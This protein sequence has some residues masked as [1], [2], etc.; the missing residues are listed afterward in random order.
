MKFCPKCGTAVDEDLP[1]PETSSAQ[2]PTPHADV[3]AAASAAAEKI[4]AAGTAAVEKGIPVIKAAG[5]AA[6][7][8]GIPAIKAAGTA[9][10]E[11]GVPV[12][13]AAGTAAVEKGVPVIK[14]AGNTA[15]EKGIPIIKRHYKLIGIAILALVVLLFLS[16][17]TGGGGNG[18]DFLN[19]IQGSWTMGTQVYSDKAAQV[20]RPWNIYI[21]ENTIQLDASQSTCPMSEA[22]YKNDALY[23]PAQWYDSSP[24]DGREPG[25][26]DYDL[27]LTYSKKNDL[28]TLEVEVFGD[29]YP[30][31]EYKR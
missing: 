27:R 6:V 7:E 3:A 25:M 10:V 30:L 28:L 20:D 23:F 14:A 29:W 26:Q 31:G 13:K 16:R 12:I 8:K 9:A 17:R 5:T 18:N 22:E 15:K 4:K 2:E 1:V 24:G 21:T 19:Q 11:K